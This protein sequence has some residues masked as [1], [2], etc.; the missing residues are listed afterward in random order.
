MT[1]HNK[2]KN[3]GPLDQWLKMHLLQIEQDLVLRIRRRRCL[4]HLADIDTVEPVSER[5]DQ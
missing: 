1:G 4:V 2:I 5:E 3:H